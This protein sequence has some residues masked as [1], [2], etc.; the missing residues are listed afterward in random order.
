TN[1]NNNGDKDFSLKA[2]CDIVINRW[3]ELLI[4][5]EFKEEQDNFD[6]IDIDFLNLEIHPAKNQVVKWELQNLFLLDLYFPFENI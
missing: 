3:E 4:E 1:T 5:K 6:D 2:D